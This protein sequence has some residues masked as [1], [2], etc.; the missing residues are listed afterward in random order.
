MSLLRK[1]YTF[2]FLLGVFFLPFNSEIPEFMSFLGEYSKDSSP[3][4]FLVAFLILFIHDFFRGKISLPMSHPIYQAF[5]LFFAYIVVAIIFNFI[6]VSDYYF[7][8]TSGWIRYIKQLIS[9]ALSFFMFFYLFYNVCITLGV[10]KAFL[11]IRKTMLLSLSVVFVVGVTQFLIYSGFLQL[12]PIYEFFDYLPFTEPYLYFETTRV[13]ATAWRPPDLAIYLISIS[14]FMFSYILTEKK[15]YKYVPFLI[16]VFLSIVSKSRTALV[17]VFLQFLFLG[18]FSYK[19]YR[20]F[21]NIFNKAVFVFLFMLP[22]IIVLNGNTIYTAVNERIESLNFADMKSENATSNK[23]RFG[24]QYANFQVFKKYPITGIGWGQQS[25]ESKELYPKW[26]TTNNYEFKAI[27]LNEEIKSFPP[28][29]NL[30]LRILAEAGIIGFLLFILFIILIFYFTYKF[31]ISKCGYNYLGITVFVVFLGTLLIW[32]QLDSFRL[33]VFWLAL[34][35]LI[36]LKTLQK[37]KPVVTQ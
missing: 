7:K 22:I 9:V 3:M 32:F 27:Y 12:I 37:G 4:F 1:T 24:I 29:Y 36:C 8:Q 35:M 2:I 13:N 18:Y 19:N 10:A 25:F 30:Y 16:V 31:F 26:A 28:G 15:W 14:G 11:I 17:A 20:L 6:N 5:I 33:Y 21:R 34:A 23:S